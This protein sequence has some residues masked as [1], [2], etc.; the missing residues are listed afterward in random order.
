M[1]DCVSL[2][3]KWSPNRPLGDLPSLAGANR[4]IVS[5]SLPNLSTVDVWRA[6]QAGPVLVGNVLW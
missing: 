3:K 1:L 6:S 4:Q 5:K 2:K